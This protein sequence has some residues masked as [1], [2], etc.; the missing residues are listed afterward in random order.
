MGRPR[1]VQPG[2]QFYR[3]AARPVPPFQMLPRTN[4]QEA[5]ALLS[6][7]HTRT[8]RRRSAPAAPR[9]PVP[10]SNRDEGSGVTPVGGASVRVRS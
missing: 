2:E 6:S 8:K 9:T 1:R 7:T 5:F 4:T 10:S 3:P